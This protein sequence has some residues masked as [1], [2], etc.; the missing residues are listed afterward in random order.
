LQRLLAFIVILAT[1][2]L[3]SNTACAE[4]YD[5]AARDQMAACELELQK[6]DMDSMTFNLGVCLGILKGLHYLSPD[7]C[8]PPSTSLGEIA[9]VLAQYFRAHPN[10]PRSDFRERSLD[11]MRSAWPC[12]LRENM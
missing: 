12:G 7:V 9:G 8:V 10:D 2:T 6:T 11:G 3:I 4:N 5:D 1:T